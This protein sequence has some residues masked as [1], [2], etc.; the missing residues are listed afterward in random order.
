MRRCRNAFLIRAPEAVLAS[1]SKRRAEFLPADVGFARQRE[2]FDR[3]SERLGT[4]PPVIDA[5]DVLRDPRSMLT[6]LC[7]TLGIDFS[8]RMLHWPAGTRP[9]DGAWAPAWY[10]SVER[11]TGFAQARACPPLDDNLKALA[12]SLRPHYEH[13]AQFKID[14]IVH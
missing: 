13:L 4:A 3:E 7:R 9:T 6:V 11:S 10:D 2:L 12:D 5:E 8:E 14:P 1:Y